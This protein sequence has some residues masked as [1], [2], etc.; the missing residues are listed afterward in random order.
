ME[1]ASSRGGE[2]QGPLAG[3]R[4]LDLSAVI[5]GPLS[6]QILADY[7]AEVIRVETAAGDSMRHVGPARSEAMG[8]QFL[9]LGRGKRSVVLDLKRPETR[10]VLVK[11]IERSDA[12]VTNMRLEAAARLSI[13]AA[14]CL[15]IN[16]AL[17]YLRVSGFGSQGRYSARPA[18]DDVIQAVSGLAMLFA[19]GESGE[20][21]YVPMNLAD[22]LTGL[23]AS[24]ALL[25]GLFHRERTGRGQ[26]IEV[27]M[28][29]SVV[30][31]LLGDH[32]AG[33]S[34]VPP[35]GPPGYGRVLAQ[36]RRPQR[37]SDGYICVLPYQ[38][39][40]W[41][42]LFAV[43]GNAETLGQ[44]ARFATLASRTAHI[45]LLYQ[46]L[47]EILRTRSTDEWIAVL[48]EQGIPCTRVNSL[49]EILTDPH[50]ADVGFFD[51]IDHPTEGRL[52]MPGSPVR[53]SSTALS[54]PGPAPTLG[55]QTVEVLRELG[56]SETE[57]RQLLP[58]NV[59]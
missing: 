30:S 42:S 22:R 31:F 54:V 10:P 29:E 47:A 12:V 44:D 13:D 39:K 53:F 28:F 52:R 46:H 38:D 50:L 55:E 58:E 25:A 1:R 59:A 56:C 6:T 16:P 35:S 15:K 33:H 43:S 2:R 17:V 51:E 19:T 4:I 37:T 36:S 34:F 40:H 57:I 7:G 26:E 32:L 45:D 23:T 14:S 3:V 9:Q 11:L 49:E 41:Q 27:P 21:R 24:H 48:S 8:H 20:P 18:Y 5:A